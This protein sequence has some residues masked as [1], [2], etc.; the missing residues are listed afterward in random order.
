MP[1]DWHMCKENFISCQD[2]FDE[3]L[4]GAR[5]YL[6]LAKKICANRLLFLISESTTSIP[7][8]TT[9]ASLTS[10]PPTLAL[11]I[12]TLLTPAFLAPARLMPTLSTPPLT[13][14]MPA[15]ILTTPTPTTMP[16]STAII[17][18]LTPTLPTTTAITLIFFF[19]DLATLSA[20]QPK[21]A[22]VVES[23]KKLL[24]E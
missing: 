1:Q 17:L 24:D 8:K 3:K 11:L 14:T 10:A 4:N 22:L 21:I 6:N 13:P 15:P 20:L 18:A 9:L 12:P 19:K 5:V 16:A 23:K 7:T 2:R